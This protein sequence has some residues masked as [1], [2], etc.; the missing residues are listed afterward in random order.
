MRDTYGSKEPG[1]VKY[2]LLKLTQQNKDSVDIYYSRFQRI[3]E[4]QKCRMKYPKDKFIYNY[5]F[6]TQSADLTTALIRT[7]FRAKT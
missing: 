3:F 1:F 6:V 7:S 5:M 4:C 2:M